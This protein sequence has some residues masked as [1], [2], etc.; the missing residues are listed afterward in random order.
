MKQISEERRKRFEY[1]KQE[2]A[3]GPKKFSITELEE[4]RDALKE[5]IERMKS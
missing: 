5:G 3:K 1:L 2:K 4:L